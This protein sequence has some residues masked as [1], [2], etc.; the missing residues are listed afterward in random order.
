MP[1][2]VAVLNRACILSSFITPYTSRPHRRIRCYEM[3]KTRSSRESLGVWEAILDRDVTPKVLRLSI[4]R[5]V[6]RAPLTA[7]L[8][9]RFPTRPVQL[10]S[11]LAGYA[12]TCT[13]GPTWLISSVTI[14]PKRDR[15]SKRSSMTAT[16]RQNRPFKPIDTKSWFLRK[17]PRLVNPDC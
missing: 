12:A 2:I 7:P 15:L 5:G 11:T 1:V 14:L 10:E 17:N 4:T 8:G 3:Q 13:T 9:A 6:C 16:S